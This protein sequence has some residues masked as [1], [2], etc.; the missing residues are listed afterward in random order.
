MPEPLNL[1]LCK[2]RLDFGWRE[3]TVIVV[4][5]VVVVATAVVVEDE[6]EEQ[7]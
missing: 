5:V 2:R 6:V 7:K 3:I 4:V 1:Y